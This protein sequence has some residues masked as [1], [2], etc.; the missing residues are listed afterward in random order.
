MNRRLVILFRKLK[1]VGSF[2]ISCRL[3][4]LLG[5]VGEVVEGGRGINR[6]GERE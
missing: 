1:G 4:F 2:F 3:V 6:I 5:L